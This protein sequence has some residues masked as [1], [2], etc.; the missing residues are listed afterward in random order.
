MILMVIYLGLS[1]S[2]FIRHVFLAHHA[3]NWLFIL[4]PFPM[5]SVNHQL[6]LT[7][8]C[9]FI[10]FVGCSR[11]REHPQ[12]VQ[13]V[14]CCQ[15]SKLTNSQEQ[16]KSTDAT[17]ICCDVINVNSCHDDVN[18]WSKFCNFVIDDFNISNFSAKFPANVDSL[19]GPCN[20]SA[21]EGRY[22]TP[23]L[24]YGAT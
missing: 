6:R 22:S 3:D 24:Q 20:T 15:L 4:P 11:W 14:S 10:T 21:R 17:S 8:F 16:Y 12:F 13:R 1:C 19:G 23:S 7:K 18:S 2:K 5:H 9:T